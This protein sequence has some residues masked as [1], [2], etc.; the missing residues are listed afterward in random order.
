M[1]IRPSS[2]YELRFGPELT[3]MV[4]ALL[5]LNAGVFVLQFLSKSLFSVSFLEPLFGLQGE[6]VQSG[7]VWQLLTYSFLHVDFFHVLFNLLAL[8][9][10]GSELENQ[11]G[12]ETFLK[13]FLFS[14]VMGGLFAFAAQTLGWSHG[15]VMGAS[16]GIYGLLIAFA[17]T[18]PN[19]EILFMLFFPL[20]AKYFVMI[21]MLMIAFAQ[22]GRVAHSAHL[23]GAVGGFLYL[24]FFYRTS[25]FSSGWSLKHYLQKRKFQRYQEE[26]NKRVNAKDEVDRL[27]EKISKSGM[28]SLSKSEKK[29][30]NE[31]SKKYFN[32]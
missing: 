9:M 15:I 10:F 13:F 1:A 2:G 18:W 7:Y 32:D 24:Q 25:R 5:I 31:A 8:W 12:G 20:K 30:L 4:R 11:W 26:M 19:R 27:L 6:S 22:G 21:L 14:S 29:F 28:D 16:G 3:P 23:G 17:M